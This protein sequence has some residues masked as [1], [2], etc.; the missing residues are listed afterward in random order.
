MKKAIAL[1]FAFTFSLSGL[2]AAQD[3]KSA[4]PA[5][6]KGTVRN[7]EVSKQTIV[8]EDGTRLS[9]SD[10]QINQVWAGDQVKAGYQVQGDKNVVT[11]LEVERFSAQEAD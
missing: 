8:L 4:N 6:A 1:A 9:V 3:M 11:D 7:V 5:E 2:A 10:K